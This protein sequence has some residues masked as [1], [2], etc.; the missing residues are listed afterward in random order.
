VCFLWIPLI[1]H[2]C[3]W[4]IM[5]PSLFGLVLIIARFRLIVG[6]SVCIFWICCWWKY[7]YFRFIVSE[8]MH[9]W[10]LLSVKVCKFQIYGRWECMPLSD[11]LLVKLYAYFRF[12]VGESVCIFQI[13]CWWKCM[14]ISDLLLVKVYAYFEPYTCIKPKVLICPSLRWTPIWGLK[15]RKELWGVLIMSLSVALTLSAWRYLNF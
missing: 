6:E 5:S 3:M 4:Q 7:A 8:S 10:D 11:S 12:I 14:H 2:Y 15:M 9:I 13:Y 1:L